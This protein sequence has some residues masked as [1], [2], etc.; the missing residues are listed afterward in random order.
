M[1]ILFGT[2][3]DDPA[4]TDALAHHEIVIE[5]D[6][7]TFVRRANTEPFDLVLAGQMGK[8]SGEILGER[9]RG[10]PVIV[11]TRAGDV[12]ARVR[13]MELGAYDAFDGSF[14]GSQI[15]ARSVAAVRRSARIPKDAEVI[16]VDGCTIDLHAATATRDDHVHALTAREIEIVRWLYRHRH[17]VV[18]RGELLEHVWGVSPDVTTRS[19]DVA[20]SALRAKLERDPKNPRVI[21]SIKG[22][23]YIWA[24]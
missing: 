22:A 18:G 20:I 17:R 2:T 24:E 15:A 21:S 8:S 19:V 14:A 13:A 12:E 16:E 1:R 6:V 11:V 3:T 9:I 10:A 23:G 5:R 7:E 4:I